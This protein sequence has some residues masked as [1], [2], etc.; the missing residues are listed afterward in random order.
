MKIFCSVLIIITSLIAQSKELIIDKSYSFVEYEGSH[1]L[2]NWIGKSHSINGVIMIDDKNPSKSSIKVSIPIFSFDSNN[3]NRDSNMLLY[4][5]EFLYPDVKFSST[6]ISLVGEVTYNLKGDLDFHG[7]KRKII[8][9]I[10]VKIDNDLIYFKGT[11]SVNINDYKVERP[12]LL[13]APINEIVEIR[14][15]LKGSLKN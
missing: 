8:I 12:K 9:P 5:E 14:I 6:S 1:F 2:H 7:I 13:L 15:Q 3:G 10:E 11:F 4:V